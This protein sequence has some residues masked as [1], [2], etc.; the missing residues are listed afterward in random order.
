MTDALEQL[1]SELCSQCEHDQAAQPPAEREA[2]LHGASEAPSPRP[3]WNPFTGKHHVRKHEKL[4]D[5]LVILMKSAGY[6][7]VEIA[8]QLGITP[9]TVSYILK[10]PWAAEQVLEE[11]ERSGRDKVVATLQGAAYDAALRL[12][13][14]SESASSEQVKLKANNDVLDRVLGRPNQPVSYKNVDLESLSDEELA[15]LVTAGRGN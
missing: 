15:K 12:I 3:L 6:T 9:V 4:E 14:I 13:E 7:N 5:R 10:Q 8:E 1:S 2:R 11:I